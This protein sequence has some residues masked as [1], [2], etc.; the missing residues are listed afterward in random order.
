LILK[1]LPV[2]IVGMLCGSTISGIVVAVTFVLRELH[3][4]RDKV[5]MYLAFGA[6]R[7]E[8]CRP[9]AQEA[10]RLALLPTLNQMRYV[11]VSLTCRK[12]SERMNF[13]QCHRTHID[14]RHDDW[15]AARRITSGTGGK[16]A[17]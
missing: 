1:K 8:A 7:V 9:I 6:S 10:L 2:P 11:L 4:N 13:W 14:S 5:E 3:D 17:K 15:S 12:T 16:A